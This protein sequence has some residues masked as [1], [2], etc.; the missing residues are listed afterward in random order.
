MVNTVIAPSAAGLFTFLTRKHIT[1]QNKEHRLDFGALT[2][3]LL[4]GC[5]SITA[6]CADVEMWAAIIIGIV[7]SF[8]YSC[9]CLATEKLK[10]DDPIEAFQVHG[11]C[12]MWG[13]IA[14]AFFK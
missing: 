2:N 1:G 6:S 14:F 7:G 8:I 5:V 3:G 13:I 9:A 12:G 10:I 4:A 11:C